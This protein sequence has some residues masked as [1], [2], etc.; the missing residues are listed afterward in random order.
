MKLIKNSKCTHENE[1][2]H[3][4]YNCNGLFPACEIT[5]Y[6]LN[7]PEGTGCINCYPLYTKEI[8]NER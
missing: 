4:C 5:R 8:Y 1:T 2:G 7:S 3:I 6:D